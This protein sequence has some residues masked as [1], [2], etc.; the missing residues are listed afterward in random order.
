[1]DIN[2]WNDTWGT[3]DWINDSE[4][5]I[6][7]KITEFYHSNVDFNAEG[8]YHGYYGKPLSFAAQFSTVDVVDL[9]VDGG[10]D[11]NLT[12]K[13]GKTP[14]HSVMDDE[15]MVKCLIEHAPT[16][17]VSFVNK[18]DKY[19]RTAL[20]EAALVSEVET[21]KMLIDVGADVNIQDKLGDTALHEAAYYDRD[22]NVKALIEGGADVNIQN[23][24]DQIALEMAKNEKIK[25]LIKNAN[26]IRADYLKKHPQNSL[27]QTLSDVSAKPNKM[28]LVKNEKTR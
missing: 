2:S 13:E 1:M 6:K 19:G 25:E 9:L 4:D 17:I 3:I 16:D 21:V 27:H 20:H 8:E 23:S 14:L 12:D 7:Q 11:I 26:E 22:E 5:K 24:G 18:Q 10:A 28:A 15:K